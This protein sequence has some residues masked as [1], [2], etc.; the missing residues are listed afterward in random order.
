MKF[1]DQNSVLNR[2]LMW[3][4]RPFVRLAVA[5]GVTYPAWAEMLKTV[6]IDVARRDFALA[7]EVSSDSRIN[8]LTG[9]HRKEIRRLREQETEGVERPPKSVAL[10]AQL[11]G[12]WVSRA[13]YVDKQGL[14]LPLARLASAGGEASFEALVGSVSKDIRSRVV[15]DEWLRLGVATLNEQDEVVLNTEAFIPGEG[16]EEKVFYFGHNLHDH[17]QAAVHNLLGVAPPQMERSVHYNALSAESVA[18]LEAMAKRIG[19]EMLRA[20]NKKA[21]EFEARDAETH[22]TPQRFTCGIYFHS[23]AVSPIEDTTP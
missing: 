3:A 6:Y 2:A 5:H 13:P 19:M 8:V 12:V 7:G 4:V 21:I 9:I 23:E 11:V 10:G 22:H 15:L 14:P 17:A 20:L 16:Y 1:P 18:E